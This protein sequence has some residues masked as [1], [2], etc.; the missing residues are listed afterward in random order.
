MTSPDTRSDRS[1]STRSEELQ[2]AEQRAENAEREVD[3]L[4]HRLEAFGPSDTASV[5]TEPVDPEM[6]A[7]KDAALA[8]LRKEPMIGSSPELPYGRTEYRALRPPRLCHGGASLPF[9]EGDPRL[10][11]QEI[12]GQIPRKQSHCSNRLRAATTIRL[13]S[14]SSPGNRSRISLSFRIPMT[15]TAGMSPQ[16]QIPA[17]GL[18]TH[19]GVSG[20]KNSRGS[21]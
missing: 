11:Q 9:R 10:A 7:T 20:R 12:Q 18:R 16:P 5:A 2:R 19:S 1:Q 4:K 21:A 3:Q 17:K 6:E 13:P 8:D 14:A 15:P